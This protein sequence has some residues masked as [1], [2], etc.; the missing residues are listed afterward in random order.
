MN[1]QQ[2]F[3]LLNATTQKIQSAIIGLSHDFVEMV[4]IVN[5]INR[6]HNETIVS[7]SKEKKDEPVQPPTDTATGEPVA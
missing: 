7:M 4:K 3:E 5:E 2:L 6:I 1:E